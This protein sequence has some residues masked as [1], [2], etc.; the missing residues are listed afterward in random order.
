MRTADL[1]FEAQP[2]GVHQ[3]FA[4]GALLADD[5]RD[6][7]AQVVAELFFRIAERNPVGDLIK[8]AGFAAALAVIAADGEP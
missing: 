8:V 7:L 5:L 6:D 4:R 2:L 3:R 1:V